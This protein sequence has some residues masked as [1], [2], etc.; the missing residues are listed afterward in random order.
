MHKQRITGGFNLRKF[1]TNSPQLQQRIDAA[2][3]LRTMGIKT[4][5][6]DS[7]DETYVEATLGASCKVNPEE[8]KVLGVHWD[9]S[10]DSLLFDVSTIIQLANQEEC[11]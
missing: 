9:P 2:E 5:H 8:Q 10:K 11:H 4:S 1:M 7:L 6:H 3:N